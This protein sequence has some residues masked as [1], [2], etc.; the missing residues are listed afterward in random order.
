MYKRPNLIIG[1]LGSF[2]IRYFP[3]FWAITKSRTHLRKRNLYKNQD[4][5]DHQPD[6]TPGIVHA[7]VDLLA[8]LY[9]LELLGAKDDMPRAVLHIV[10]GHVPKLEV[11]SP[12]QDALDSPL[13]QL[14]GVVLQLIGEHSTTLG[15][16][17]LS[18]VH[19]TTVSGV[20]FVQSFQ[21][22]KLNL[23]TSALSNKSCKIFSLIK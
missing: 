1:L 13:G 3:S 5:I 14:A 2:T 11:V 4:V 9:R 7:K 17:L 8:K 16:Q 10:P 21:V 12:G 23:A 6:N 20:P 15:V 19:T 18:P 22:D